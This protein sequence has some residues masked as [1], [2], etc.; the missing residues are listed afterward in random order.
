MGKIDEKDTCRDF[1]HFDLS[2]AQRVQMPV[3]TG[4]TSVLVFFELS[5]STDLRIKRVCPSELFLKS[6]VFDTSITYLS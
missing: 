3:T 5:T 2:A 6:F 4:S 1:V